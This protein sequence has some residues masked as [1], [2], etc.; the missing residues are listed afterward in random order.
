MKK[1]LSV[2][3]YAC[4][5]NNLSAQTG[6]SYGAT[7][8][9]AGN[10]S[11]YSGGSSDANALFS[12][13]DYGKATLAFTARYFFDK[14]WSVQSGLGISSIGFNYALAKNYSLMKKDD[15]FTQ[16]NMSISVMQIPLTAIYAF[17]PNC[18]N[19]RW[20]VG[21]G[22]STM[23][24]FANVNQT[25]HALPPGADAAGNSLYLDQTISAN[26]FTVLTGQLMAGREKTFKKGGILQFALIANFGFSTI[27][28]ST[29][30][31]TVDNKLYT[32]T[33]S[34]QGDYCGFTMSYYFKPLGKE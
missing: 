19:G 25:S 13:N 12:N 3:L 26:K 4:I 20:I 7:L 5:L 10:Q 30:S 15:H 32:H 28:N 6:I 23:S 14:H 27:A 24:N 1:V 22:F 9:I 8:G 29:V 16:N 18:K 21:A 2:L 33:F 11:T 31:Y 34:N 17:N